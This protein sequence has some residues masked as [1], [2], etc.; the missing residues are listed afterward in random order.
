MNTIG[1]LTTG[2]PNLWH[3]HRFFKDS[4]CQ[5]GK[6]TKMIKKH[7]SEQRAKIPGN[8]FLMDFGFIRSPK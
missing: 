7:K 5:D 8:R 1:K 2:T 4:C 6:M 3:T